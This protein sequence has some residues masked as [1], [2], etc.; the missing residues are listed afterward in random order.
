MLVASAYAGQSHRT[1]SPNTGEEVF[2]FHSNGQPSP[3]IA[4][5]D[6]CHA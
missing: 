3:N 2:L 5:S 6:V 1:F 4:E